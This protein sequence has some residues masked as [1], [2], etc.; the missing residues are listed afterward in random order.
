MTTRYTLTPLT[1]DQLLSGIVIMIAAH[2]CNQAPCTLDR[3][4]QYCN[5][6]GGDWN[7]W[8]GQHKRISCE[9]EPG[10]LRVYKYGKALCTVQELE[11]YELCTTAEGEVLYAE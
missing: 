4:E 2:N 6:W 8:V 3:I 9:Q 5:E 11:L 10:L 1:T 7:G